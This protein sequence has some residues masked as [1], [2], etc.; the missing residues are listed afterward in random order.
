MAH[1]SRRFVRATRGAVIAALGLV[2]L[3]PAS[4]QATSLMVEHLDDPDATMMASTYRASGYMGAS[5]A[6]QIVE[7]AGTPWGSPYNWDAGTAQFV[8]RVVD[9]E[10]KPYLTLSGD[11]TPSSGQ[12]GQWCGEAA[13]RFNGQGGKPLVLDYGVWNEPNLKGVPAATYRSLYRSC[14]AA[15]KAL[16][17]S[18]NV[19]FGELEAGG[20]GAC[21][22]LTNALPATPSPSDPAIVTEG[23]AIHPYQFTT[24]PRTALTND[25]RGIGNLPDWTSTLAVASAFGRV[26]KPGGGA[27]PVLVSEFGYCTQR[28]SGLPSNAAQAACPQDPSGVG[29]A[30]ALDEQ[31]RADWIQ[32]AYGWAEQNGVP[33]FDYHGLRKRPAGNFTGSPNGYLWESGIIDN[34]SGNLTPS[35]GALRSA[36]GVQNPSVAISPATDIGEATATL[37]GMVNP[38]GRRATY[39]FEYGRSTSYGSQTTTQFIAPTSTAVAVRSTLTGLRDNTTYHYRLVATS[40]AGQ[41][42]SSDQSFRTTTRGDDRIGVSAAAPDGSLFVAQRTETDALTVSIRDA[43]GGWRGPFEIAAVGA[44]RSAPAIAVDESGTV[45]IAYRGTADQLSVRWRHTNGW[46]ESGDPAAAGRVFSAPSAAVG[47][48][49]T[50]YFGYRGGLNQLSVTWRSSSTGWWDS[51]DPAGPDSV[52]STPSA[53]VAGNGDMVVAYRGGVD[54]FSVSWRTAATGWWQSGDPAGPD[55]VRSA[56]SMAVTAAGEIFAVMGGASGNPTQMVRPRSTTGWSAPAPVPASPAI[57]DESAAAFAPDGRLYVAERTTVDSLSLAIRE[58]DG[59]WRTPVQLAAPGTVRSSPSV[60]FDGAGTFFAAYR[61]ASSQ[62]SVTWGRVGA[63]QTGDPAGANT[64]FSA[65]SLGV[66]ENR[67]VVVAY[68]GPVNQ[69]SVSWWDAGGWHS[70]DPAGVNNVYSA[71]SLAIDSDER[72]VV[73]Y[74]GPVNQLSVSWWDAGG[75]HSGDPGLP[76]TVL[77]GPT[78]AIDPSGNAYVTAQGSDGKLWHMTWLSGSGWIGRI[79]IM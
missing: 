63:W 27:P 1:S 8:Q 78:T 76:N 67:R 47:Q 52:F 32:A 46:W 2:A 62:L 70:G 30:F 33:I 23:V 58:T 51:G 56:P 6:R 57:S 66:D 22:Y 74:R 5:Y 17:P 49:G 31:T 43:A 13:A 55:Q 48:D 15:I 20:A 18:A 28:P 73:A 54:Q 16:L 39:Y 29:N 7:R 61:G 11:G 75:W 53:A 71:P 26:S 4:A 34:P 10:M 24:H 41:S 3:S 42:E 19:Y 9:H 68:R 14:R 72:V 59:T 25:C 45:F 38:N 35:V 50:V 37:T 69:L 12:F 36:T 44:V 77:S 65:P 21:T 79:P 40:A 64:V 60:D